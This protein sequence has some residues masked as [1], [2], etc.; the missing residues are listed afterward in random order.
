MN[1]TKAPPQDIEGIDNTSE[2]DEKINALIIYINDMD[3]S[4]LNKFL[5]FMEELRGGEDSLPPIIAAQV[6]IIKA[7]INELEK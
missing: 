4:A 2:T 3:S 5:T 6:E 7:K 1:E